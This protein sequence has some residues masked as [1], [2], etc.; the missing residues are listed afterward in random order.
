MG[1]LLSDFVGECERVLRGERVFGMWF[2]NLDQ[3]LRELVSWG[4]DEKEDGTLLGL[5]VNHEFVHLDHT[6]H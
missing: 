4:I 1:L 3:V 6:K 2:E 5:I